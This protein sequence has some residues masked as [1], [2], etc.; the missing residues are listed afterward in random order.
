MS[1]STSHGPWATDETMTRLRSMTPFVALGGAA[2]IVG[3]LVA[4][5]TRPLGFDEGSWV[6]AYL[7][8]VMGVAQIGLGA[9]QAVLAVDVPTVAVRWRQVLA[10]TAGSLAVIGGTLVGSPLV[11]LAGGAV[12]VAALILFLLAVRGSRGPVIWLWFHRLFVVFL[13]G[14]VVVGTVLSFLRHG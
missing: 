10:F 11:V 7:V 12:L 3:G 9:G 4:A 2:I 6:A 13:A 8:L 1:A 14:S 5:L